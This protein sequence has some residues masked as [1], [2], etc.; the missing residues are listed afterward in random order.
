VRRAARRLEA[1]D[2][3]IAARDEGKSTFLDRLLETYALGASDIYLPPDISI[4][5]DV[6]L[7]PMVCRPIFSKGAI[8]VHH[9]KHVS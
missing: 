6:S 1:E 7:L 4:V 2:E 5:P 8:L 3:D 9:T